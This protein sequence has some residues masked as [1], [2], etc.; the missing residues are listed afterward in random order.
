MT[1]DTILFLPENNLHHSPLDFPD[2]EF[3]LYS[4]HEV[5]QV[6]SNQRHRMYSMKRQDN[7]PT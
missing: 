4:N 1:Y 5:N 2:Q 3:L 6:S 7:L